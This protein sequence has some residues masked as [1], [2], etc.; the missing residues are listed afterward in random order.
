M[1]AIHRRSPFYGIIA[2]GGFSLLGNAVARVALPRF[3]FLSNISGTN[4]TC[5]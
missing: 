2:A 1:T 4:L 5:C 3:V